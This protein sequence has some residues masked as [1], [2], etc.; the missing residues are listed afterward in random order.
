M[1]SRLFIKTA[2][3]LITRIKDY[4]LA[5]AVGL[6]P[7]RAEGEEIQKQ[8]NQAFTGLQNPTLP[9]AGKLIAEATS[10]GFTVD[11]RVLHR[12]N[13]AESCWP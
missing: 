1:E 13:Q 9:S 7:S 12:V 2:A 4:S 6:E 10:A 5:S 8:I 11:P 3:A